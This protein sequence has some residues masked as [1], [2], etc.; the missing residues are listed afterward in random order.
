MINQTLINQL[1][2][3]FKDIAGEIVLSFS[4]SAHG[5]QGDLVSMLEGVASASDRISAREEGPVSAIPAFTI[6]YNGKALPVSF[7]GIPGGHEF[8]SLV[9][10]I[11]HA[12]GRGKWPDESTLDRIRSLKGPV[13]LRTYISLSCTN[14]PDV[15]QALNQ[16]SLIHPDFRHTMIDGDFSQ[17]DIERLGIQGVPAV[18]AGDELIHSGRADLGELLGTLESYFGSDPSEEI[19]SH[20]PFDVAVVGG[21]P[22]GCS[23]AIYSARKG[24]RTAVIAG[25][26][27]GQVNDTASISNL[28]SV[29]LTTGKELSAN[30]RRHSEDYNMSVFENRTIAEILPG[31]HNQELH[32]LKSD[33]GEFFPAR[34]IILATG[35]SWRRLN[36]P[37][38]EEYIG[39]GVAFCPHCDGPFFAGRDVAVVGGG[40]SGVEAA[41]DLAAVCRKVTLLEF[42]DE[43]K[44]DR[45]LVD[46]LE[47]L[48][49]V[50][51]VVSA[52]T[53]AVKGDGSRVTSLEYRNRKTGDEESVGLDGVFVQIGLLPNSTPAQGVVRTTPSGEIEIDAGGR[54]SVKG[55]YAAGDV[56]TAPFKQIVV[57]MGEGAK[58]SLSA[59][60]DSLRG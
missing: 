21:G 2:E 16:M 1:K 24:L 39:R 49:N 56:T 46:R 8:T 32:Q 11:L 12:D 22:A 20:E 19:H 31:D 50:S 4:P 51:I 54:T 27:G 3:H 25:R 9:L 47:S 45:V 58:A 18:F 33:R 13:E 34:Q 44:A 6:V 55:I 14:C 43:L 40:N 42:A 37:G 29:P 15:V 41:I 57:A 7:K 26:I 52:E 30:L 35:A 36:I 60:E 28:I 53:T 5:K 59:F 48:E 38:E 10:A 17:D 23:A